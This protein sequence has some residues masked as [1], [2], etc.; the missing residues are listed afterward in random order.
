MSRHAAQQIRIVVV[1]AAE[2]FLVVV[3]L[4]RQM[5]LVAGRTE[6]RRLV[7][8]LQ[9]S[10]LVKLRLGLDQLVVDPLQHRVLAERERIV[11]RLFDRVVGVAARAVDVRDRVADGAGDAALRRRVAGRVEVRIVKGTAEERHRVVAAGA[12][13]R[14]LHAAVSLERHVARFPHAGQV[15]RV[16]ERTESMD[17]VAPGPRARRRGTSGSTGRSSGCGPG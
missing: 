5:H 13:A 9:E 16:V 12:P 4:Q 14:R 8:R 7:K 10:R 3:Q 17:A 6:L 1:L 15:R 2:K 11:Q